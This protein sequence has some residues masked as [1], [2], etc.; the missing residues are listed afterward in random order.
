MVIASFVISICLP[1]LLLALN[2]LLDWNSTRKKNKSAAE[3]FEKDKA[4]KEEQNQKLEIIQKEQNEILRELIKPI[5]SWFDKNW[6]KSQDY[7]LEE[8]RETQDIFA[9]D[10][11]DMYGELQELKD[12]LSEIKEEIDYLNEMTSL[13]TIIEYPNTN[14]N[15]NSETEE[16]EKMLLYNNSKE[17]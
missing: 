17:V 2:R 9:E 15:V 13:T 11:F 5:Q 16:S 8:L 7:S 3:I 10:V 12:E 14:E 4:W 6:Q 1:L